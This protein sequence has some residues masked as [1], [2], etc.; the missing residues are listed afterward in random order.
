MANIFKSKVKKILEKLQDFHSFRILVVNLYPLLNKLK[1]IRFFQ[2][3][4]NGSFSDPWNHF[5]EHT[6]LDSL[7]AKYS[8]NFN[9]FIT[10]KKQYKFCF[11]VDTSYSYDLTDI[12][13]ACKILNIDFIIYNI[14]DPDF[15][16]KI[17]KD[18]IDGIIIWPRLD[19][20]FLRNIFHEATHILSLETQFKL[21]PTFRELEIYESKRSLINFLTINN[22]PHP[23]SIVF[24][25]FDS[26]KK[27]IESSVYPIVFKSHIGSSSFGVEILK[28]KKQALKLARRLFYKYYLR[29]LETEKRAFEWGYML[30]QEYIEDVKEYRII[31]IGDSWFGYQKWKNK[32]QEFMSGSGVLKYINPPEGLLN[33][34]YVLADKFQFTTMSFDVF[35]NKQGA[36]LVNELQTWFGSYDPTEMYVDGIPGRYRRLD[37]K[38]VFEPG[39]FNVHG[40]MLLRMIHLISILQQD[41]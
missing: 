8:V 2:K 39:F 12:Q 22:I 19:N 33:F 28:N 32:D 41:E 31:K 21:Y 25:D 29:K 4:N 18:K 24:Y 14:L 17:S 20:G 7:P 23:A 11:L 6:N 26:A 35:E 36:Y 38:W 27:Y 13:N 37:E 40:S 34:C 16:H 10:Q 5:S 15:Y 1:I 3:I 30:L 9:S